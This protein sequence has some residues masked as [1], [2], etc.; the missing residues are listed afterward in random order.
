MTASMSRRISL[1]PVCEDDL[2]WIIAAGA[3]QSLRGEFESMRMQSPQFFR[4][5]FAEDGFSSDAAERLVVCDEAGEAIGSASHF[6]AH[7]YSTAREIGWSITD[8]A[9]RG[10]GYGSAIARTLIDYLFTNFD[11]HRICCNTAPDNWASR[12]IAEKAGMQYEGLLRGVIFIRGKHVD[13]VV[14]GITRPDWQALQ[15]TQGA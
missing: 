8:P 10:Q 6:I 9:R 14:Y 5:R 1:R 2:P 3:N 13:G 11:I 4:K 12:R 7:R 15:A